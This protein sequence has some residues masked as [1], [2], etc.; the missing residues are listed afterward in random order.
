MARKKSLK[1]RI[2]H[3]YYRCLWKKWAK[4]NLRIFIKKY[5]PTIIITIFVF[6]AIFVIRSYLFLSPANAP[7][8]QENIRFGTTLEAG[9]GINVSC[10]WIIE[11]Y[12]EGT[13]IMYINFEKEEENENKIYF[14]TFYFDTRGE[15]LPSDWME[16][17]YM[18]LYYSM[19]DKIKIPL[20]VNEEL[21]RPKY[22]FDLNKSKDEEVNVT[23]YI[24]VGEDFFPTEK[25]IV[26]YNRYIRFPKHNCILEIN[27][28]EAHFLFSPDWK[29]S[30]VLDNKNNIIPSG[31]RNLVSR[32]TDSHEMSYYMILDRN[33]DQIALNIT[34]NGILISIAFAGIALIVTLI[35]NVYLSKRR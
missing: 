30:Y 25:E 5:L 17:S 8:G 33:M 7:Q 3:K 11:D 19:T 32:A 35:I 27:S 28:T 34:K 12:K 16:K 24:H 26:T 23:I 4:S 13:I 20:E 2:I 22:Y 14:D 15:Q 31:G 1:E 21:Y 9:N 18:E 10:E 29:I 6:S